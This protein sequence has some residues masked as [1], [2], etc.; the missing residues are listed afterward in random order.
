MRSLPIRK[1]PAAIGILRDH[2][3]NLSRLPPWT[4][5]V[6]EPRG[7]VDTTGFGGL[8]ANRF[9]G[10]LGAIPLAEAGHGVR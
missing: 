5:L 4:R 7:C 3:P 6:V 1:P 8:P 10:W 9:G 2:G